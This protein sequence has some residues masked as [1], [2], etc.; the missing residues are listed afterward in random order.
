MLD[1]F[2]KQSNIDFDRSSVTRHKNTIHINAYFIS[3][4]E[5]CPNC[6]SSNLVK[7]GH[8]HKTVKH[9]VY[10]SSLINVKCNFQ[11]YK[12]KDCNHIFQEKNLFS[13]ENIS[14]SYES[15]YAILDALKSP[16]ASF[17]SVA[18]TFHI[19][20]QNVIDLFDR[21][22]T[23]TPSSSLPSILSFDEKHIGK[24]ITD[25]SYLF[26]ILDWR[27]I[28][29]YD[30]LESRDKY[31]LWKYFSSIPKE[32]RDKV[33]HITMDMWQTYKDVSKHFFRNAKIAVDSFHVM[34]NIN[35]AMNK[36]RTTVMS[37][38]NKKTE[39]LEDNH[40]YYYFLKKFDY[41][42][43]KEF[44]DITTYPIKVQKLKTKL[45]KHEIRK[46]LLDIDE[47]INEAYELTSKYREFNRTANINNCEAELDE[48][49]N[50]F[51]SSSLEQFK[52]V[53]RTLSNW[54][55]EIINSFIT[56]EDSLTTPKKVDELPVPRRISNG[57]IEGVNSIIEQVKINGKG[58]TN[59]LRFKKRIIY[60]INK[61]LVF[62]GSSNKLTKHTK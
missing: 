23:Y 22:F 47:R 29:I 57:P 3:E 32:E 2:F 50:L 39:N 43:T 40:I 48:L 36:V 45:N 5:K 31:T 35:K 16:N 19:S 27:N 18:K 55:E 42:F 10:A 9:C 58:Y 59:F 25:H 46:Y 49:I 20:R 38:Y 62:K 34:E 6:N 52:E 11:N 61:E 53:G 30:V 14:F 4:D 37:K 28:K 51:L 56:I 8:V 7:N 24:A 44:D 26:V 12:C 1:I 17:E 60:V 13:P 33:T 54:R 15:I 41:F 21:F